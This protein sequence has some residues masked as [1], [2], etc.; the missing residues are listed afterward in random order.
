MPFDKAFFFSI[1]LLY[2]F[3]FNVGNVLG[4]TDYFITPVCVRFR[5][6]LAAMGLFPIL[7]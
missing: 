5:D 4:H 6:F 7:V 3:F 1:L 2:E